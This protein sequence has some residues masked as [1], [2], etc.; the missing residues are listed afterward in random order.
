M[1]VLRTRWFAPVSVVI[2]AYT[3]ERWDSLS[4]AITA[5]VSQAPDEVLVV[6]DSDE[7]VV[8]VSAAWADDLDGVRAIRNDGIGLTGARNTGLREARGEIIVYLDDDACPQPSW[9]LRMVDPF[10]DCG[11]VAVGGAPVPVYEVPRPSW[12]PPEF[13]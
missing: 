10:Q 4:S 6:V 11:V 8:H 5:A 7:L 12:L 9:L 1:L 13:D 2:C 3:M